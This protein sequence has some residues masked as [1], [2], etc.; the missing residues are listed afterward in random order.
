MCCV[1]Y[2][3]CTADTQGITLEDE[4]CTGC[5]TDTGLEGAYNEGWSLDTDTTPYVIEI[6]QDNAGMV[7]S[8][9]S[10]DYVSIP[11]KC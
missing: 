5:T 8:L 9:C 4:T 2:Q 6:T 3:V 7:D 1:Q 11:C 10:G